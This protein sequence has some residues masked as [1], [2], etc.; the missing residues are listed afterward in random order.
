MTLFMVCISQFK[1]KLHIAYL[2]VLNGGIWDWHGQGLHV[3]S[4]SRLW[5]IVVV[6]RLL[7]APITRLLLLA[8]VV[9]LGVHVG[10]HSL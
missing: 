5:F 8:G 2:C 4:I 3:R 7:V 9:A 6:W 1:S 10:M